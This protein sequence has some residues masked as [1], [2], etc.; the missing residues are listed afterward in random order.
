[1][2]TYNRKTIGRRASAIYR[3]SKSS[4][5]PLTWA[6]AQKL[7]WAE[8][9]SASAPVTIA[10]KRRQ[11]AVIDGAQPG[12]VIAALARHGIHIAPVVRRVEQFGEH[13]SEVLHTAA[14]RR[15]ANVAALRDGRGVINARRGANGGWRA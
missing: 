2:T 6:A 7:A 15:Q 1:M 11:V 5:S 14:M 9:K 8:A 3:E 10:G 13:L 4:P 12:G